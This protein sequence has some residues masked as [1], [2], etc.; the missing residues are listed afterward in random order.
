MSMVMTSGFSDSA[1]ATASRP[2]LALPTT[3]SCSSA[4]KI[5]SRTFRM[6]VE[7]STTSTRNFLLV[8]AI[9][10]LPYRRDGAR[11]LR[12]YKLFDRRDQLILLHRLGQERRGAFLNGAIAMLCSRARRNH[13]HR[14]SPRRWALAQLHHQLVAGHARHFEVG[15]D[16][17]AAVLCHQFGG[18]ESIRRQFHAVSVLLQHPAYELAHAD[19]IVRHHDYA[20]LLDAIDGLG[21]NV[22]ARNR[23]RAGCKDSRGAG[24]GL[25]RPMLAWFCRYHAGQIDQ[26]DDAAIRRDGTPRKEFHP[27]QVFAQA[28]DDDFVLAEN[29]FHDE[30]DLPVSGICHDHPEVTIDRFERRQSKIGIQSHHLGD[31]VAYLGQQFSADGFNFIG[32]KA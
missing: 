30:A 11:R 10:R 28:L 17:M 7:S 32:A 4:L 23:R 16:Q 5:P 29:F 31:H 13:H 18:F 20:L 22:S 9:A 15:N 21:R 24:A 8:V 25:Y 26:D 12:S 6:N 2:S 27:P 3:C 14:D 19:R 1:S